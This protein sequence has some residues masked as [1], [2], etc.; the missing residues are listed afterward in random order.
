MEFSEN[1]IQKI[2]TTSA[3]G[4]LALMVMVIAVTM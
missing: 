2:L 3:V 4:F 1:S